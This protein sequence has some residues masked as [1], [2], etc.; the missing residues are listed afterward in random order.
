MKMKSLFVFAILIMSFAYLVY[1]SF[2]IGNSY[3]FMHHHY[4][5]YD[6]SYSST[7]YTYAILNAIAYLIIT[8]SWIYFLLEMNKKKSGYIKILNERL[9]KGEISIEEYSEI[10][11]SIEKYKS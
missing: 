3:G 5:Y 4:G 8:I 10:K 7:Y 6:N 2:F 1:N 9:S 11:R